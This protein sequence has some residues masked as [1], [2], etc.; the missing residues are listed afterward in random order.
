[1]NT[2]N[3]A[4]TTQGSVS[5]R[6]VFTEFSR[7]FPTNNL[8]LLH[9]IFASTS[10]PSPASEP[11]EAFLCPLRS[12]AR[13]H[14]CALKPHEDLAVPRTTA[15]SRLHASSE[16]K[17]TLSRSRSVRASHSPHLHAIARSACLRRP[18]TWIEVGAEADG[19]GGGG[20]P[21]GGTWKDGVG[22]RKI[23]M[24]QK[25]VCRIP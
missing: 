22:C 11:H 2:R 23:G 9:V 24:G 6:A 14:H 7:Q 12:R 20:G 8:S 10:F 17:S 4:L 19:A 5:F 1:M 16:S 21:G 3:V 15:G 13:H 25:T 18:W